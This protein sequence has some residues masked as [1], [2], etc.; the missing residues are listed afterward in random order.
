MYWMFKELEAV[1]FSAKSII[2]DSM[3]LYH[4]VY[5]FWHLNHVFGASR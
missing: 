1:V 2:I 5:I 3:V 4:L